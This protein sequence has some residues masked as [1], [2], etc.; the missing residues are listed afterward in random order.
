MPRPKGS[1]G[2]HFTSSLHCV[3]NLF[4][5]QSTHND[6]I[7]RSICYEL[8]WMSAYGCKYLN[9]NDWNAAYDCAA[10]YW[11]IQ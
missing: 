2:M 5:V 6:S 3:S 4:T 11:E 10:I 9:M 1:R 8:T 7:C